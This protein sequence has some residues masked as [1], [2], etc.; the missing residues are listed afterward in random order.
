LVVAEI[1]DQA[2]RRRQYRTRHAHKKSA[3][4]D[5]KNCGG[6]LAKTHCNAKHSLAKQMVKAFTILLMGDS[7]VLL[8]LGKRLIV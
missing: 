5:L 8:M 6:I 7:I 2:E 4:R 3:K 1:K